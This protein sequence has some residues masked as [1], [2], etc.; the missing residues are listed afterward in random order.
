MKIKNLTIEL[1]VDDVHRSIEFY[2]KIFGFTT[3]VKV[4]DNNPFFVIMK[5]NSIQIMLYQRDKFVEEIPKFEKL[6]LGGSIVIYLEIVEVKK[7]FQEIKDNVKIIQKMHE[8][9]YGTLEFS[10]EDINSYVWMIS[11]KI[12]PLN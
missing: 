8:T 7:T 12:K 9:N 3:F 1:M 5:N 11:E 10:F 4:P 6:K 2:Q